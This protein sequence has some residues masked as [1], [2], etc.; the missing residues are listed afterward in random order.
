MLIALPSQ[1]P[2]SAKNISGFELNRELLTGGVCFPAVHCEQPLDRLWGI[3]LQDRYA[4][5]A[6]IRA[7]I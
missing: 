6:T 2:K 3:Y 1:Q 4:G 7:A 5:H